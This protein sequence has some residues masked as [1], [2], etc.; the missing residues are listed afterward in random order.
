MAPAPMTQI[1]IPVVL[2]VCPGQ[3]IAISRRALRRPGLHCRNDRLK[4]GADRVELRGSRKLVLGGILALMAALT[5]AMNNAMARRGVLT[6]S[7]IQALSISVPIGAPILFLAAVVIAGPGTFAAFSLAQVVWLAAAGTVHFVMGRYCNYRA[8]KAMGAN[9]VGPLQDLSIFYSMAMAVALLGEKLS[10][11]KILGFG[12]VL[13]GPALVL[14]ANRKRKPA[15]S[16]KSTFKP[17]YAEGYLFAFMSGLCYGSSPILVRQGLPVR[18]VGAS[19]AASCISYTGAALMIGLVLLIPGT[20][21]ELRRL[22]RKT[23]RWFVAAGL[24]VAFSQMVRY[25][26]LAI[27][28]VTVVAPIG[29]LSSVFRIYFGWLFNREHEVF[30]SQVIAG[31]LVS[32]FGAFILTLDGSYVAGLFAWPE[33][34]ARALAWRWP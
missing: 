2:V 29:R 6:G 13:S 17:I 22:D 18:E 15:P 11:L 24:L 34:V 1:R 8:T 16:S 27:A 5:F 23:A 4:S 12:L 21:R 32:L 26:A 30:S 14:R 9:L 19:I 10:L 31:T 28:P 33:A 20:A 7:V 3:H 25:M